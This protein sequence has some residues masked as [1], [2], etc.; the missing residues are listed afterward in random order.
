[1]SGDT[2]TQLFAVTILICLILFCM[3]LNSCIPKIPA[4]V[5]EE[6]RACYVPEVIPKSTLPTV[7]YIIVDE[8]K[9]FADREQEENAKIREAFLKMDSNNCRDQYNDVRERCNPGE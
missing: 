5:V 6:V 9:C 8:Y 7:K 2:L 3:A 4:P 1:M